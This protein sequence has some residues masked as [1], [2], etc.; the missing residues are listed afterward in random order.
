MCFSI[1]S[2]H[3][4]SHAVMVGFY[5]DFFFSITWDFMLIF[6]T[7]LLLDGYVK[8]YTYKPTVEVEDVEQDVEQD[9]EQDLDIGMVDTAVIKEES[10]EVEI[11]IDSTDI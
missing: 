1:L 8:V 3:C 7:L 5:K 6:F 2:S 11:V 10:M 9:I 4:Y